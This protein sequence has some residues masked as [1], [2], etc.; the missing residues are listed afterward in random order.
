MNKNKPAPSR[1]PSEQPLSRKC[2]YCEQSIG[3]RATVCYHCGRYQKRVR[4]AFQFTN[5]ISIGLLLAALWQSCEAT[6]DRSE[7]SEAN[8]KA[9]LALDKVLISEQKALQAKQ[10]VIEVGRAVIGIAEIL[11]RSTGYGAGLTD[12]DRKKLE[13]YSILLK[14]KL[15]ETE[16]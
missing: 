8:A 13:E 3:D 16:Q 14:R 6:R 9:Q 15:K 10:D 5:L 4:N 7:A 12:V 1:Q 2:Y 11:P